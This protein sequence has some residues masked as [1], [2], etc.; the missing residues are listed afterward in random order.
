MRLP[1]GRQFSPPLSSGSPED[2]RPSQPHSSITTHSRLRRWQVFIPILQDVN[3][4]RGIG[5]DLTVVTCV[6]G[7]EKNNHMKTQTSQGPI[8]SCKVLKYPSQRRTK[9][10]TRLTRKCHEMCAHE[11]NI[12]QRQVYPSWHLL[13]WQDPFSWSLAWSYKHSFGSKIDL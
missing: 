10:S 12:L 7:M 9:T 6:G 8:N 11:G 13:L 1:P 4:R 2:W 3:E 5:P